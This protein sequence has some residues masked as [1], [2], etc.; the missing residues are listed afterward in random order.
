ALFRQ[1][2]DTD[3]SNA[4]GYT[5]AVGAEQQYG[6]AEAALALIPRALPVLE[7]GSSDWL[8]GSAASVRNSVQLVGAELTGDYAEGMRL[9]RIGAELT[10]AGV[11]QFSPFNALR[12]AGSF[13]AA[14][15]DSGARAWLDK[16]PP[17][18]RPGAATAL[19]ITRLQV[20]GRLENWQAVLAG[21]A[22]TEKSV[23]QFMPEQDPR[24]RFAV[25]LYPWLAL[26]KARTGDLGGAEAV[27]AATPADCYDCLR[28][29]GVIAALAGQPPR[30]DGWFARAVHDAPSIPFAYEDWGR[31]LL[32]R[33]K[34]DDAIEKFKL[35]NKKGPHFADPL[36]G[37]G[38]ALM[39]K[40]QSHLA[41]AKFA[42]AEK[43]APNWGR[44]HLKWGEA[45][46]YSGKPAQ[47]KAQFARAATLDLTPSEKAE[48]ARHP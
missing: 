32:D 28:A 6:H 17:T 9:A 23:R 21:E 46:A 36:E 13:L 25:Q 30:A 1:V 15:H 14:Q 26:A 42:E 3:P 34:P 8:P 45:L 20:E 11:P 44:L 19:V 41:L 39:A 5:N 2:R 31:A 7:R 4:L 33:G 43:Y 12:E 38:E 22:A 18:S 27:I 10:G 48:L 24:L 40:S 16:I 37:W 47:A 35:A 29:R